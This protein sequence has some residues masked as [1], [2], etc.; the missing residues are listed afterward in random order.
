MPPVEERKRR[1]GEDKTERERKNREGEMEFSE[2]LMRK[3]RKFQGPLCK[4]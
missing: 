4:A 1:Q 3:S 2:G